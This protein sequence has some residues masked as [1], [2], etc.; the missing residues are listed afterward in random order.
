MSPFPP[1]ETLKGMHVVS[2][3]I[4]D[5]WTAL[6]DEDIVA[7]VLDGQTA[8]Y[9]VLMRRHNERIYR[10]ARAIIRDEDEAEDVM[11]QAHVNAYAHLRQF[12]GRAK[13]STWLTKIAVHE[14]LARARKRGRYEAVDF[15]EEENQV[16]ERQPSRDPEHRAFAGELRS[17]LESSIDELPDG[18][19][20]VFMLREVDGL[21]TAETA[22]CL[23]VSEDVVKTR[24]SRSRAALR[25][26]LAE[27]AGILAPETFRFAQP[28]CDRVVA[29]VFA[30]I[31]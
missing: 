6:T 28:R 30:R 26:Q 11:Q 15:T 10:A 17:L 23:G 16:V 7:R 18:L 22:E 9:E 12:D 8:L 5:R 13:F 4:L 24:L 14:A 2:G 21:N 20:E 31:S 19:R 25:H 3:A 29:A 27:R 1:V